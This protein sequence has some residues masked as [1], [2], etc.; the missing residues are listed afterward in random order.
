ME[1]GTFNFGDWTSCDWISGLLAYIVR[2]AL[3][4]HAV[5]I[6]LASSIVGAIIIVGVVFLLLRIFAPHVF[7]ETASIYTTPLRA[8]DADV[9]SVVFKD[10]VVSI[11]ETQSTGQ[12]RSRNKELHI[13]IEES[14][15]DALRHVGR[16][17]FLG[18]YEDS[19]DPERLQQD[20][21]GQQKGG[22]AAWVQ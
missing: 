7:L 22:S 2:E 13:T 9:I 6:A 1:A 12:P 19:D 21:P 18:K 16:T 15:I 3:M 8:Q 4:L 14:A 10:T 20:A 11:N 17:T 5:L